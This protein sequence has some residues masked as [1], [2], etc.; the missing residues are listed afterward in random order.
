MTS[1]LCLE[2]CCIRKMCTV[3]LWINSFIEVRIHDVS[4]NSRGKWLLITMAKLWMMMIRM[5][6]CNRLCG[7]CVNRFIVFS[8]ISV[9]STIIC[10]CTCFAYIHIY[11]LRFSSAGRWQTSVQ[12]IGLWCI[13][14]TFLSAAYIVL[15]WQL[16]RYYVRC[17]AVHMRNQSY[18]L[19][20]KCM[21]GQANK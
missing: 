12:Y 18:C 13:R 14:S 20:T 8:D 4:N 11:I 16:G 9:P 19:Y 5:R 15:S 21:H 6:K 10:S 1:R 17:V 7:P 3:L 2:C